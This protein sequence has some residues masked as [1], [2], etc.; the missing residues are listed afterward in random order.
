[1]LGSRQIKIS[2]WIKVA[3]EFLLGIVAAIRWPRIAIWVLLSG[4]YPIDA[5]A[6]ASVDDRIVVTAQIGHD[7]PVADVAF[8]PDG[9]TVVSV[10]GSTV[11]IWNAS[12]GRLL[13]SIS[14]AKAM[15]K[16]AFS[17]DGKTILSTFELNMLKLWDAASGRPLRTFLGHNKDA[18][19]YA[20]AFSP[21]GR[22]IV[23]AGADKAIKLWDAESGS[24]LHT[25]KGHGGEVTALAFS[26]DGKT[27][28]SASSDHTVKLWD[29]SSGRNLRTLGGQPL[30][31]H[32]V[33]FSPDGATVMTAGGLD[34][35][36]IKLWDVAS[37]RL[38]RKFLGHTGE[39]ETAMFSPDGATIVSGSVDK[40]I[41]VWDVASGQ[42]LQTLVGHDG[43][44]SSVA[45]SPDGRTIISGSNDRTVRLWDTKE[46]HLLRTLAGCQCWV[47]TVAFSPDG[48]TVA[49]GSHNKVNVWETTSGRALRTL[50]N[51]GLVWSVA[52]SPDGLTLASGSEDKTLRLWEATSG[53]LLRRLRGNGREVLHVAY[54]PDGKMIVSADDVNKLKLWDPASGRVLRTLTVPESYQGYISSEVAFSPDGR[55]IATGSFAIF[56]NGALKLWS[57]ASG[58]ELRSFAVNNVEGLAFSPDG[59]TIVSVGYDSAKFWDVPTGVERRSIVVQGSDV[60][61]S[62]DGSTI[63]IGSSDGT[64]KQFDAKSG[65]ELRVLEGHAANVS[66][67]VYS[68]DGRKIGSGSWDG[69]WRLWDSSGEPLSASFATADGEWV[70]ITPEGFFDASSKGAEMLNVVRGM[71]VY[72]VDQLYPFLYRPDLVREKLAGD[73]DAL[74]RDAASKLDL[75]KV[76]DGRA[77]PRVTII[78]PASGISSTDGTVMIE[79]R[80]SDQGGGIGNVEWRV[81]G[82]VLGLDRGGAYLGSEITLRKKLALANGE[83]HVHVLAYNTKGTMVSAPAEVTINSTQPKPTRPPKLFVLSAGVNNY[84]NSHLSQLSF[85]VADAKAIGAAMKELGGNLYTGIEVRTLTNAEVTVAGLGR[86]FAQLAKEVSPDDVFV[87]FLSGHGLTVDGRFYF[88]PQDYRNTRFA[89]EELG[90]EAISQDQLQ[91]W[92]T[93]ILAHKALLLTDACQSGALAGDRLSRNALAEFTATSHL[94]KSLG[95]AVM[96]ATTDNTRS[97]EAQGF[98]HGVFT[99][100]LLAGFAGADARREG[101]IDVESLGNFVRSAVPE[102]TWGTWHL[103]QLPQVRM[104][105]ASF[106]LVHTAASPLVPP[107]PKRYPIP[108]TPSAVLAF[109]TTAR[110]APNSAALDVTEIETGTPVALI[111]L[112]LNE[113][114]DNWSL[115]ARQGRILGYVETRS[116]KELH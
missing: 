54:S 30:Y 26:P 106:P 8:S 105:G 87:F 4:P 66:A 94:T 34:D 78:E 33:A 45:F 86:A 99:Y 49:S 95:R 43:M 77:G 103:I 38:L 14:S 111:P 37:G 31:L 10:G 28:A 57:V 73:P 62:R 82:V 67:V 5:T 22:M 114:N 36:S 90:A 88:V 40:T 50:S 39:V 93:G 91:E 116:L 64:L 56:N 48:R 92:F 27:I 46:G 32:A 75:V 47:N 101:L 44:V 110:Q 71:E 42:Q 65:R 84:A 35:K 6:I 96:A 74:V 17:P 72:S 60:A 41:K 13:R 20:L 7:S 51:D 80:L 12:S 9:R 19:I 11:K 61:F 23:S 100:A 81:N 1:M 85:A 83:N 107:V 15:G 59:R 89:S 25:I 55:T 3:N 102:L 29:V 79:A 112:G 76:L 53:R 98:D 68:P 24:E 108:S 97:W 52:F 18:M 104:T 69:T 113:R 109:Q 63:V 115:I 58:R 21:D 16:V 2:S 70:T